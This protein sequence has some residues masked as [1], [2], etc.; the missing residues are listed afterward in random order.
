[1]SK[2]AANKH[3]GKD[4]TAIVSRVLRDNPEIGETDWAKIFSE[5]PHILGDLIND[6]IKVG[7]SRAGRPGKRSASSEKA[8]K[9]DLRRLSNDDHSYLDFP[10]ALREAMKSKS[11]RQTASLSGLDK[12]VIGRL[13]KGGGEPATM[14]HMEAL[15]GAL[16]KNP[17]YFKEYRAMH[18]AI[19][20]YG[21]MAES[22]ERAVIYYDR[23]RR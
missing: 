10:D 21:M 6:V 11:V 18:V 9:E 22:G 12:M 17:G 7:I 4:W 23:T 16:K 14:A 2:Q 15:S 20:V 1:M 13:L 5:D 8:I 19:L 3:R